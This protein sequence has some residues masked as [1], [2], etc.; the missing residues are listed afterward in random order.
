MFHLNVQ[1]CKVRERERDGK[2]R[3]RQEER[4]RRAEKGSRRP[5][6]AKSLPAGQMLFR[7]LPFCWKVKQSLRA[8]GEE[9]RERKREAERPSKSAS[10]TGLTQ[11]IRLLTGKRE[12]ERPAAAAAVDFFWAENLSPSLILVSLFPPLRLSYSSRKLFKPIL[13]AFH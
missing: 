1:E 2:G 12:R 10:Q 8:A 7:S 11:T 3:L 13:R 5:L 9:D 6:F 4:K